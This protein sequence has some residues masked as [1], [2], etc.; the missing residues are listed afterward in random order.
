MRVT[1]LVPWRSTYHVLCSSQ[2]ALGNRGGLAILRVR[3]LSTWSWAFALA[4]WP[5]IA[6]AHSPLCQRS[7]RIEF[8]WPGE[9]G[10]RHQRD[11]GGKIICMGNV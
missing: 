7:R 6:A 10:T 5:W 4:T 3:H 2:D 8:L 1:C 11:K 9:P